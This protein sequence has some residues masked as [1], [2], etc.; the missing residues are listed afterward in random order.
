MTF[1]MECSPAFDYARDGPRD[2]D[3]PR[4]R[5]FRSPTLEPGPGDA[6]SPC[7]SKDN[8]VARRVHACEE[9]QSRGLRAAADRGRRRL[10]GLLLRGAKRKSSSCGP[11]TTGG[12][13]SRSAPTRAAGAR[14]STARPSPSSCSPTSRRARSS[15][16]RPAA[17]PRAIGGERN[18]D[19]RYTWI[20]D[21]AFTLY[22]LLR[23]G[24]TEEAAG[25]MN[26][27]EARCQQ[28]KADGSLQLMY[29][30][31]GRTRSHGGDARPPRR[32]PGL[33]PGPDRQRRL[34]PASARHLRRADGR[35]LPLQQV[36]IAHLLRPVDAPARPHQLG[37]RQLA[38]QR[39]K[40]S[41][42][43]GAGAAAL[44]VLQAHVLG[45]HGPGLEARREALL[46]RRPRAWLAVRDEI[47][48]EIMERGWS[49][50]RQAFVQAYGGDTLDASNLIMPLVFF[51][52]PSDPRMLTTLDAINRPPKDGGLVSNSLVY[53]YDVEKSADGLTGE[54]GTFNMCTFWLV[55]A[56]TRGRAARRGP[57]HLR[58][59]ARLRQPPGALRGGDR[60]ERRG[61]GQLPPGLHPPGADQRR[62]QPR[63]GTREESG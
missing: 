12:A 45:R 62:L 38:E 2:G 61:A 8:G 41:G 10:W 47:Y 42:R 24:F 27:L 22:G 13:G 30:I 55:E 15:P 18:W 37:L 20:R 59:D 46:P 31:D 1:R 33:A 5:G 57:A 3:H 7:S 48:E 44:R 23:I 49:A 17:C 35:R 50:E 60:A 58:A 19:Y 32:L 6:M 16:P 14:W 52:S 11:S 43:S 54:E 26:W 36:R 29:G 25:F 28:S 53:R 63:P 34:R 51:I 4:R 40:A 21:A 9:E 56:L 39:T